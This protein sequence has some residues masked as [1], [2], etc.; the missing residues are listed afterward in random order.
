MAS[1][2]GAM[3]RAKGSWPHGSAS[4]PSGGAFHVRGSRGGPSAGRPFPPSREFW[5]GDPGIA[6]AGTLG[7]FAPHRSPTRTGEG[8]R[9]PRP[10]GTEEAMH[11]VVRGF[12][13]LGAL[14]T[15]MVLLPRAAV[16]KRPDPQQ[17]ASLAPAD[18]NGDDENGCGTAPEDADQV[19]VV[20]A[21]AAGECDCASAASHD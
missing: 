21:T 1:L 18:E 9:G 12:L 5:A 13:F 10:G 20:R 3:H 11:S 15:L 2:S 8:P 19:A 4:R 16:P 7:Q 6:A 17:L 14:F